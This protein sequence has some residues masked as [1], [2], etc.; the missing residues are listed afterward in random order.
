MQTI[1]CKNCIYGRKLA[2]GQSNCNNPGKYCILIKFLKE[3][4]K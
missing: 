2:V 3:G 4:K 1:E